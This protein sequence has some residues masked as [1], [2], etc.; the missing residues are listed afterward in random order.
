MPR[1]QT[2]DGADLYYRVRGKA[3]DRPPL[4]LIHGWCSNLEHWEPLVKHFARQHRVLSVDRRGLG[5]SKTPGTGHT[6][7]QHAADIAA[8]ARSLDLRGAIAIGHAGGGPPTLELTRSYRRLVK[9]AVMIDSAMY[10]LPRIGNPKDPFGATLGSM[11]EA[12]TGPNGKRAFKQMY[13]GYFGSKCD[14]AVRDQA[15]ADAMETPIPIAVDELRVMA[16]STQ[17]LADD[18]SQPVL[19]LTANQVDQNYIG[20]HLKNVQFA[21]VAGSGHFPQLEVPA[22]TNAMIETFVGQL[23]GRR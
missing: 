5:R 11:I 21:E 17:A 14:R 19:W 23:G 20:S 15:V 2:T 9:A 7:K 6:A 3:S 18:I 10:A 8:I 13:R 4:I 12:L 1:F 22:Q 16:V